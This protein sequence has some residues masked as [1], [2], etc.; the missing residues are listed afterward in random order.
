MSMSD[1]PALVVHSDG[2]PSHAWVEAFQRVL[3]QWT[4]VGSEAMASD[5]AEHVVAAVV[6]A[7]PRGFLGQFPRLRKIVSIGT[8]ID[9]L[10]SDPSRPL[11]I[12]VAP[13]RDPVSIRAMA[14]FV[15]MQAL[16]HQRRIGDAIADQRARLWR[17]ELRGP[18]AGVLISVLGHGP[19]GRASVELLA[20]FGCKVVA[21]S[22]TPR[23]NGIVAVRS[24]WSELDSMFSGAQI[25][26]NML[27]STAETRGLIDDRRL[28]LLSKGAGLINVGRADALDQ[29]AL[30]RR[31]DSG[32]LALASL[33]VTLVEPPEPQDPVW[34]HPRIL[35]TP[36]IA[37]LPDPTA[38]AEW[39]VAEALG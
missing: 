33:D 1:F 10:A 6:W 39:A 26:V 7:P 29:A 2:E 5:I 15:L 31:L 18:L 27:P 35:L 19:M 37:S 14:E 34:R 25:L 17:P 23:P 32:D 20:Q 22:R 36:H 3:P 12:P 9:H 30:I 24:G 21:W 11:H 4:V 38:F 13:R 8:G 16:I 28:G